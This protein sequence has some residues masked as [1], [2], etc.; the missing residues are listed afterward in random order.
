MTLSVFRKA[1]RDSSRVTLWMSVGLAAYILMIVSIYPAMVEQAEEMDK[2]ME[3][4]PKELLAM[5]YGGAD[6][7]NFTLADAANFVHVYAAI[8]LILIVGAMVIVQ[9]FN[10]FTNAERDGTMDMM[11]SLPISRRTLLLGRVANTAATVGTVLTASFMTFALGTFLWPEFDVPLDRLAL[12]V[13]SG[14]FLLMVVAC[15]TYFLVS[16]VPS[17]RRFAGALAYLFLIGSY[18]IYGLSTTVDTLSNVR[19][20]LIF[21]Y[22]DASKIINEGVDWGDWAILSVAG[23]ICL[24]LAWWLIDRKELGV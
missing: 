14:F 9:A 24:G 13:Y 19:P 22:Y 17:S 15:F 2:L 7:D 16:I 10:G 18:L 12:G 5:F 20:L 23:L 8:Y 3:S 11:L 21:N 1:F 6:V 4:Y